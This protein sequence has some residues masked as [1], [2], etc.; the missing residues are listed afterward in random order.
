MAA[1]FAAYTTDTGIDI[2]VIGAVPNSTFCK[3]FGNP[4]NP[5][6]WFDPTGYAEVKVKLTD[7]ASGGAASIVLQ[8]LRR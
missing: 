3:T 4:N 8:Q 7:G 1:D 2:G 6:S 5:E